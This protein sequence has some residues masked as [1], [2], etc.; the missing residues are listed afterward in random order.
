MSFNIKAIMTELRHRLE[1]LYG[2]R[3]VKVILFG[4]Q[5]R[6]DAG[7]DSD[8]DVMLVLR[9]PVD[10]HVERKRV[11]PITAELSL[12]HDVVILCTYASDDRY[13]NE[14]SPLSLNVRAEGVTV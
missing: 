8:I 2:D 4:S 9:G 11:I 12:E 14:R 5:A 6:G 7:H 13:L 1:L 10:W 3:L